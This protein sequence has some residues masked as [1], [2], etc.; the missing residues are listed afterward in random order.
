MGSNEVEKSKRKPS[1]QNLMCYLHRENEGNHEH[2]KNRGLKYGTYEYGTGVD[3]VKWA[4]LPFL[5][6]DFSSVQKYVL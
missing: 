1:Q 3:V 2:R 6:L 5:E 4:A